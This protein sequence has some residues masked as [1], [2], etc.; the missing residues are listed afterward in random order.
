MTLGYD[1]MF[2]TVRVVELAGED[3]G[4]AAWWWWLVGWGLL[5]V[6]IAGAATRWAYRD[7][8]R[9]TL[10]AR[11]FERLCAVLGLARIERAEIER[12]AKRADMPPVALLLSRTAF[13]R[14]FFGVSDGSAQRLRERVFG[15]R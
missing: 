10:S 7:R 11:S 8:S 6:V 13:E 2:G 15:S 3:S 14:A 4:G 9:L 5:S 12:R 1:L